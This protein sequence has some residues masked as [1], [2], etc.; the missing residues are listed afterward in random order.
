MKS[1]LVITVVFL[2]SLLYIT[3]STV[4]SSDIKSKIS[5]ALVEKTGSGSSEKIKVIVQVDKEKYKKR[6]M[7]TTLS[8]PG[9]TIREFEIIPA[10]VMEVPANQLENLAK[11][12]FV[13]NIESVVEVRAFLQ[14]SV[15]LI[16]AT[17]V[18]T[19]QFSG[20]NI[21]G[22]NVGVC[23]LDT[24][25]NYTHPDL[26][27]C[28]GTG[29]R[30]KDGYNYVNSNT[31]PMD[32]KGH[33]TYVAGIA[34]ANGGIKGVAPNASIIAI[35]VLN[36]AGSGT[37]DDLISGI[38]WCV[39]NRTVYNISVISMSLG[40]DT[41]FS[42]YCDNE[43]GL[44]GLRDAI[45]SAV[46]KNITVVAA[47]G[48][49]GN[50]TS[51][52]APAC[53][54]NTTAVAWST[55]TDTVASSSNRNDITDLIAPGS[56]INSTAIG[57][58]YT[59]ESGTSMSTPH[60]AGAF[61][62]LYQKYRAING[63][64]PTPSYLQKILN[65]TGRVISDSGGSNLNFMRIDVYNASLLINETIPPQWS[66]QNSNVTLLNVTDSILLSAYW[67]DNTG[68][69]NAVL[70]TNETGNWKNASATSL[71]GLSTWSNFTWSNS[72]LSNRTTVAWKI[73]ANDTSGN[74]NVTTSLT[75]TVIDN[76]S[77]K[78]F[79][80]TNST[81]NVYSP[82]KVY[83]FN[84]T[85][86]DVSINRIV[87][88]WNTT[89]NT[90]LNST[91]NN[92]YS[93]NK[94][95]LAVG[96]YTYR[97]YA[98]DTGGNW[99]FTS[100]QT[101]N[102]T[103]NTSTSQYLNIEFNGT[104]NSNKTYTYPDTINATAW[105]NITE[106]NLIL[107]RNSTQINST[108]QVPNETIILGSGT[109]NYTLFY[110]ETQNYSSGYR[111]YFVSVNRS[112]TSVSLWLNDTQ[113]NKTFGRG[114]IVNI[115]A[116]VN[117]SLL[118]LTISANFTGNQT[119]IN[120]SNYTTFN[121]TD[122]SSLNIGAY[123]ITAY[124]NGSNSNYSASSRTYFLTVR[125]LYQNDSINITSSTSTLVNATSTT[126]VTLTIVTNETI[127]S[128]INIS[129]GTDNPTGTQIPHTGVNKFI[130][131]EANFTNN[132]TY[133]IL[134]VSYKDTNTS[135]IDNS[136]L[137]VYYWNLTDWLRQADNGDV[138]TT[139][140]YVWANMTH[141]SNFTI[142]GL[143]S[144]G[145]SC[146]SASQCSGG[147]CNSGVC[148]SSAPSTP[149][150][151]SSG[152]GG[153]SIPPPT[154]NVTE[155]KTVEVKNETKIENKTFQVCIQVITPAI[156]P[157]GE[158]KEFPTPCDVPANWTKVEKCPIVEEPEIEKP[159]EIIK[160]II[161]AIVASIV[162]IVYFKGRLKIKKRKI[163]RK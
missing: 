94:T 83:Q 137:R 117:V 33:G 13:K 113:N 149:S 123:N 135:S 136:S 20:N 109:Y 99:N 29:C 111:T 71:S 8:T 132:L 55:K 80:I 158:C 2:I 131:I 73:Y 16:N 88:E 128:A 102:I 140:E 68:L 153:G 45:N 46:G 87:F 79:N 159:S 53:I 134:N 65:D 54:Q 47:T 67:T 39:N 50:T 142:G 97:W 163:K 12:S 151:P 139:E 155:K 34:A 100:L 105:K 31:N 22:K 51:I 126:N 49:N 93:T 130:T 4:S 3:N 82:N 26:G 133:V 52:A 72:S 127:I 106:G 60:V 32:D 101:Y 9:K 64:D 25:V 18:W 147:Y 43:S 120:S 5:P 84:T 107:Y 40:T 30:V 152:G 85:W 57:G 77:P 38:D 1:V 141:L 160:L 156:S 70:S 92:I 63:S 146:T 14:D 96:N 59:T 11:Q 21:T 95:D 115:T 148:A 56:S 122:T 42:T 69:A 104:L 74:Q 138:N 48:N 98:N 114:S 121:L 144:N 15:P 143:L 91:S 7:F 24:G 157:T 116:Q 129:T 44:T 125:N 124:Y 81:D 41:L 61:A 119:D 10:I 154:Q 112:P 23:I 90:T 28:L 66:N 58:G 103:Q 78:Y 27:G 86:T 162:L 108:N 17:K 89:E 35:K 62:L 37:T 19:Q 150:T 6:D 75:F 145:Q 118:N 161:V 110:N 36:S 76:I